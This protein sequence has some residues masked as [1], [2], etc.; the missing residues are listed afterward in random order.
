VL[1]LDFQPFPDETEFDLCSLTDLK[2]M[3]LA[4]TLKNPSHPGS[5]IREDVIKP[6]GLTVTAAA[7][8]LGVARPTLS[9][10][11]NESAALT[12]EMAIR[13]EKA[14]G[15]KAGHF[16]RIQFAYDEARARSLEK[17]IRVKRVQRA[18]QS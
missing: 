3:A 14:F 8:A 17:A 1:G 6:L 7:K 4:L 10:L 5:I 12:W 15:P 18:A 16:M 11:L 13:I 9:S 2:Q